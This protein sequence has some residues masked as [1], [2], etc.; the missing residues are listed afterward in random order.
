MR[1]SDTTRR[2][3]FPGGHERKRGKYDV[4]TKVVINGVG[5]T[6]RAIPRLVGEGPSVGPV[7]VNDLADVESLAYSPRFDTVYGRRHPGAVAVDNGNLVKVMSWYANE[8]G[9]ADQLL[10]EA[11]SASGARAYASLR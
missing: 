8:R 2:R 1:T 9:Y 6:G 10:R 7:A 11:V 3:R 5:R 4:N